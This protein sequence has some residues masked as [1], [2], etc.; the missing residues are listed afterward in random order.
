[1]Y[2][3]VPTH[4]PEL[5]YLKLLSIE[6]F[7][8]QLFDALLLQDEGFGDLPVAAS[9]ASGDLM[10]VG[11]KIRELCNGREGEIKLFNLSVKCISI[12]ITTLH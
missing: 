10:N 2:T 9:V 3:F 12:I 1:L 4:F 11:S 6:H 8:L 7:G 5:T